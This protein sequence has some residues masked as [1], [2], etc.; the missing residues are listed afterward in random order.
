MIEVESDVYRIAL[1]CDKLFDLEHCKL[2][3]EYHYT[4]LPLCVIDCI[5]SIGS[6]YSSTRNTVI[7]YCDYYKL[8]RLQNE[9]DCVDKCKQHTISELKNNIE[10]MGSEN[11]AKIVLK[12]RQRTSTTNVILKSEAVFRWAKI[13]EEYDIQY[14]QDIES[15]LDEKV[16][17]MLLQISGQKSGI[18]L[19]YLHMLC[20]NENMCKP[21][22]HILRFLSESLQR[23]VDTQEAQKIMIDCTSIL[24]E[25]Y[26]T[27]KVRA[28]DYQIWQMMRLKLTKN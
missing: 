19:R 12:N 8:K 28:L 10:L 24:N 1:K 9:N 18:S 16:E 21:D 23:T 7:R 6:R 22:R 4:S 11:F 14:I 13:L 17:Q 26:P 27:L 2:S 15:K 3:E 25:M 5:F 20:G